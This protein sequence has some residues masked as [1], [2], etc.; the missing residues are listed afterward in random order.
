M[1]AKKLNRTVFQRILGRPATSLPTSNDFWSVDNG[2]VTIE[3]EKAEALAKPGGAVRLEGDLPKR[4]LVVHGENGQFLAYENKCPHMGRRVDPVPGTETVQCCSI[5]A[6]TFDPEGNVISG[7]A[8]SPLTTQ[9]VTVKDGK[10]L[11]E[12]D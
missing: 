10:L 2:I 9:P 5:G 4:V 7:S 3:L 11:I 8:K 1:E 6:S 12:I